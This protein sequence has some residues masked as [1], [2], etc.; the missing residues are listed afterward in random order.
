MNY[1]ILD[2]EATCWKDRNINKQHEI[3]E[4][5]AVKV[6]RNGNIESEFA[7]FVKPKLHPILSDFCKE[8]TTI[9]QAEIDA[10][11]TYDKVISK[12]IDWIGIDQ[13]YAL[14]SWGF[15]DK[16]QF[17]KD[18]DLYQLDK[19][20]LKNHISVKHQYAQIKNLKK[21]VGMDRALKIEDLTL[22][23]THHRGID[24]ARNIAKIF[25]VYFGKWEV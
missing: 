12:F 25:Q 24:D 15:Y 4:I 23:G 6:D 21:P 5:G 14:G 10:A 16:T 19:S 9:T 3:I 2:L 7:E 17:E 18:C 22:E 1:I 11:E 20:W 8:L 13:P